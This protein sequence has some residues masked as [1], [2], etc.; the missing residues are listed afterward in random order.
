MAPA[1]RALL[2]LFTLGAAPCLAAEFEGVLEMKIVSDPAA[3]GGLSGGTVRIL[4]GKEG[5]RSE[6]VTQPG[7][8]PVVSLVRSSEPTVTYSLDD[9][10]R[11]YQKFDNAAAAKTA[12]GGGLPTLKRLGTETL[13]GRT[14]QHVL[15]TSASKAQEEELWL[16]TSLLPPARFTSAFEREGGDDWWGALKAAGLE[17]IP[18]KMA[19]R[20]TRPGSKQTVVEATRVEPKH[21]PDSTFA[22]PA[23]YSQAK[24]PLDAP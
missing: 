14:V 7:Q 19:F 12:G 11:T 1:R 6:V 22:V 15:L 2:L 8:K 21:L 10:T 23:G 24:G 16:D 13:L 4:V 5:M 20:S 3:K 9:A 17:G 18:L